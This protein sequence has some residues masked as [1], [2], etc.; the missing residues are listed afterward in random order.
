MSVKKYS[1][2]FNEKNQTLE[3]YVRK[4]YPF[5]SLSIIY[6]AFRKKDIKVNG[7]WEN[8]K[9]IVKENDE[10]SIYIKDEFLNTNIIEGDIKKSDE[11]SSLIIYE[12]ENMLIIN[13]PRGLLVQK[14]ISNKESLNDKVIKYLYFKN[15]YNPN[16]ISAFTPGPVHRLDRN[17]SGLVIFGK[18]NGTL[19][20]FFNLF[21]EHKCIEKHYYALVNG[22]VISDD[23]INVPLKKDS[24]TKTVKVSSTKNGGKNALTKYHIKKKYSNYTLLDVE[25]LTGRTHQIRVHMAYINHPIIGDSK[26]GDFKENKTFEKLYGFKNQFLHAYKIVFKDMPKE[27]EYLNN[28]EIIAPLPSDLK[29][30]LNKLA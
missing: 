26:Y 17:T 23:I 30:I 22:N 25:L 11:I 7:H 8:G 9:Y 21:K 20:T 10:I 2:K 12:D 14:D 1:V 19:D 4:L 28:K 27:Y 15:E 16:E 18:N 6:K 24:E 29:E 13:K 3:K 5:V